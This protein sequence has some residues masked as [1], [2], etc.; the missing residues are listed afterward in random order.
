MYFND[1]VVSPQGTG[2]LLDLRTLIT[3]Q[4]SAA[5]MRDTI[6]LSEAFT[7]SQHQQL[8]TPWNVVQPLRNIHVTNTRN[9]SEPPAENAP[10]SSPER[11][12]TSTEVSGTTSSEGDVDAADVGTMGSTNSLPSSPEGHQ[13][14]A[15]RSRGRINPK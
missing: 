5:R 3:L 10:Q 8:I 12:E 2:R 14:S 7:D 1:D 6:S 15:N 4:Y 9:A 13:I 11:L